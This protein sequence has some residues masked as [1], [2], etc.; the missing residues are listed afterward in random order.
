ML[1]IHHRINT[2]SELK[3]VPKKYGI[4]VDIRCYGKKIIL[5]H[6]PHQDGEELDNFLKYYDHSFIILNIKEAGIEKEVLELVKNY[7]IKEYF[8]LDVEYP[9][10]YKSYANNITKNIAI[11]VSEIE[12]IDMALLNAGR[13][14]WIWLD[15]STKIPINKKQ[16]NKLK[17]KGYKICF[18]CPSNLNRQDDIS[19]YKNFLIKNKMTMDAVMTESNFVKDWEN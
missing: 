5:N 19:K 18:V 2:I 3:N 17:N 13:Y 6:D 11:R 14:N 10:V 16:Y 4:E 8:F 7:G 1:I 9:F 15:V 12:P